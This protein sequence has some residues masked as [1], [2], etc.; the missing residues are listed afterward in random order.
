[1]IFG[2]NLLF[3]YEVYYKLHVQ[4]FGTYENIAGIERDIKTN[5]K[6]EIIIDLFFSIVEK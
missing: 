6:T 4:D 3:T 5:L 1:M 2:G